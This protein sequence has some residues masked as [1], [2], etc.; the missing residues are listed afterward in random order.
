MTILTTNLRSNAKDFFMN[1]LCKKNIS[2]FENTTLLL[3]Q[4]GD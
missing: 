2:S 4:E 3:Q 1:S